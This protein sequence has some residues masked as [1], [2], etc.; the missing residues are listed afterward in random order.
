LSRR[1][2]HSGPAVG[3]TR[4]YVPSWRAV[5]DVARTAALLLTFGFVVPSC[6]IKMNEGSNYAAIL[7]K[8]HH[9]NPKR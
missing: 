6:W 7:H 8:K 3:C 5:T 4:S 1:I 2:K 9:Q